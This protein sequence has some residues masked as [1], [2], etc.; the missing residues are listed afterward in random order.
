MIGL[1]ISGHPLEKYR[2]QLEKQKI[3][4]Q[5][6]KNLPAGSPVLMAGMIEEIKKIATKKGEPMLFLR[7]FDFTDN[8]EAVVFPRILAK[9]GHLIAL[10]KV[11]FL[12]GAISKRNGNV[13]II[14]DEIREL[15][16]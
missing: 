12:K 13:G 7:L 8:I 16:N 6:A 4:I 9:Y 14:C 1:Y 11:I 5:T 10:E 15:G 3:R 2:K